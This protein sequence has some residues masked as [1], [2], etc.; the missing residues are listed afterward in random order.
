MAQELLDLEAK[1]LD[2]AVLPDGYL[3]ASQADQVRSALGRA[4]ENGRGLNGWVG[5]VYFPRMSPL[6]KMIGK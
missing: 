4:W 5:W 1:D 6:S 3:V 2:L